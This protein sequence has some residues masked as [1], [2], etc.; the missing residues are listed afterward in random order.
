MWSVTQWDS[1]RTGTEQ[2]QGQKQEHALQQGF[3]KFSRMHPTKDCSKTFWLV[4]ACAASEHPNLMKIC[5]CQDWLRCI[6]QQQ[7]NATFSIQF[8]RVFVWSTDWL[9]VTVLHSWCTLSHPQPHRAWQ[10]IFHSNELVIFDD[11][12]CCPL[13]V[14]K[15]STTGVRSDPLLSSTNPTDETQKKDPKRFC[16]C[17]R[18]DLGD[19]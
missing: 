11:D 9:S 8:S 4:C 14:Q 2:T 19:L 10:S 13:F 7:R 3:P 18:V 5:H 17:C 15:W 1:H 12:D 6:Q 16:A